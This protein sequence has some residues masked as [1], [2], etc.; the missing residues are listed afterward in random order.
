M[1]GYGLRHRGILQLLQK[2]QQLPLT[3]KPPA[4]AAIAIA[5]ALPPLNNTAQAPQTY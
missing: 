1:S 2:M 5:I 3:I 4:Y